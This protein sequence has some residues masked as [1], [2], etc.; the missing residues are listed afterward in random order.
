MFVYVTFFLFFILRPCVFFICYFWCVVFF[1]YLFS[2]TKF[3]HGRRYLFTIFFDQIIA[4][5]KILGHDIVN[6]STFSL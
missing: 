3:T 2:A 4:T 5:L 6:P 1:L